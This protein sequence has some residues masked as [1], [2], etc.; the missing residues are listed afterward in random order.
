MN[1]LAKAAVVFGSPEAAQQWYE[2]PVMGLNQQRPIDLATTREGI[3]IVMDFLGRIEYG[4][5]T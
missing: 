5:Y 3:A 1:I 2:N 4:V